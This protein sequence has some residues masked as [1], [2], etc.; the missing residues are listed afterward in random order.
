M[1]NSTQ[2]KKSFWQTMPGIV[3]GIAGIIT[4]LTGLIIALNQTGCFHS[5]APQE[6]S[7]VSPDNNTSAVTDKKNAK[8]ETSN[9]QK[10]NEP[11]KTAANNTSIGAEIKFEAD[12]QKNMSE[13]VYKILNVSSENKDNDVKIVKVKLRCTINGS[14]G[15]YVKNDYLRLSVDDINLSPSNSTISYSEYVPANSSIEET[16]EFKAS[17]NSKVYKFI[18]FRDDTHK[19]IL[20]QVN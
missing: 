18:F 1:D 11:G 10:Q 12:P 5:S 2:E 4:A 20:L 8:S 6:Q 17:T 3:T 7:L 14:N 9:P 19:E 13:L 15:D 16:L